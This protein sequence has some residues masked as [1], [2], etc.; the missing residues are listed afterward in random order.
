MTYFL[1]SCPILFMA[2]SFFSAAVVV[3][4]VLLSVANDTKSMCGEKEVSWI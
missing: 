2:V 4:A 3:V 1:Y